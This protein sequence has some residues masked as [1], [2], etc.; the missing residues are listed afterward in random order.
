MEQ[1]RAQLNVQANQSGYAVLL[2]DA[3]GVITAVEAE[4]G[5]V[6]GAGTPVL[7]LAHDGPREAWFNVPEDR[8]AAVRALQGRTGKL[9]VRLWGA[10]A[11]TWPATVRDR[12]MTLRKSKPSPF[13]SRPNASAFWKER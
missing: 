7:R 10:D 6:V 5:M 4:P 11:R 2:A 3:S 8:V 12:S 9:T 13:A 1:A